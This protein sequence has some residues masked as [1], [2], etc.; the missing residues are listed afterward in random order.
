M[1]GAFAFVVAVSWPLA[2][3]AAATDGAAVADAAID[4]AAVADAAVTGVMLGA[5]DAFAFAP[6]PVFVAFSPRRTFPLGATVALASAFTLV[7]V[8]PV[9]VADFCTE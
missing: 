7:P 3:V 6:V 8:A 1:A 5:A 4:G 2:P 9:A